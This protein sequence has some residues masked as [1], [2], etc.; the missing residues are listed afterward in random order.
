MIKTKTFHNKDYL[1]HT[2]QAALSYP[3]THLETLTSILAQQSCNTKEAVQTFSAFLHSESG[4]VFST[5]LITLSKQPSGHFY[6]ISIGRSKLWWP[7]ANSHSSKKK[8]KLAHLKEV[9][10]REQLKQSFTQGGYWHL[11]VNRMI[12]NVG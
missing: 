4:V 5:R 1:R 12:V 3:D 2:H 9:L 6:L 10:H 11:I 7:D 8:Q